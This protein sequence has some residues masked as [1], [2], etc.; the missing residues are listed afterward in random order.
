MFYGNVIGGN[1]NVVVCSRTSNFIYQNNRTRFQA[2]IV[3]WA[4]V[5]LLPSD[6][7]AVNRHDRQISIM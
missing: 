7:E 2:P 6:C 3:F 1:D 4:S 5:K